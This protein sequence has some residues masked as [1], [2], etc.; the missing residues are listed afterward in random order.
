MSDREILTRY[1]ELAKLCKATY[2]G[3]IKHGIYTY[4]GM[5]FEKQKI[6]HGSFGRGYCRLFW[7]KQSVIVAFR[8]TRENVDWAI[9]NFKAFPVA[10]RDCENKGKIHVHRGFQQTLDYRDKSTKL[11]SLDAIFKYLEEYELLGREIVITGHSLGGALAVLFAT[12]FRCMHPKIAENK[13][14]EVVTFGAPAVGLK[15]FKLFYGS[16][17]EKTM[18]VINK[19]DAVPFTPPAF[20]Y[21][22]GGEIWLQHD[23][24][25]TKARWLVRLRYALKG[26]LSKLSSDHDMQE[27]IS[28]LLELIKEKDT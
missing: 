7:N 25:S 15:K 21:H 11:R 9:S 10:L 5:A 12:K 16:L 4:K 27:Y 28:Q 8:G 6:V 22:V 1:Y 13:I 26:G 17:N 24:V 2:A 20:Y 18:R 23:G 14:C 19:S 3:P